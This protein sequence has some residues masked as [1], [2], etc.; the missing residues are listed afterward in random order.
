MDDNPQVDKA[1]S[2]AAGIPQK[3]SRKK[4]LILT[5]IIVFIIILFLGLLGAR[6]KKQEQAQET[7]EIITPTKSI[8]QIDDSFLQELDADLETF[9]DDTLFF[10]DQDSLL[11]DIGESYD[12]AQ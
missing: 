11:E 6:Q 8:K 4:R 1:Y 2:S 12:T 5:I 3:K 7:P 10:D 9:S